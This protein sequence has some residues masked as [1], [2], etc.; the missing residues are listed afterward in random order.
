MNQSEQARPDLQA[1]IMGWLKTANHF[2]TGPSPGSGESSPENGP[3]G[4]AERFSKDSY[5]SLMKTFHAMSAAM[6]EPPALDALF[7]GTT[8]LPDIVSTFL[9]TGVKGYF[10]L[11]Q[12]IIDKIGR[13]GNHADAY[14]FDNIDQETLRAWSEIYHKEIRQYFNVPQ[15]G[16]NRFY[17][18]RINQAL[19]KFNIFNTSLA[20]FLQLLSL[21]FE[22]SFHVLQEKIEELTRSGSL[23]ED[24][25]AYYQMWVKILEGRFMTLFQSP[26]YN[27]S[28]G[29][30]MAALEDYLAARN[31]IIQDM[32][33]SLP[34][35]TRKEMDDLCK[36]MYLLKKKV[37]DLEK[38]KG[39]Q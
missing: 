31:R 9:L 35:P 30:T 8:I 12:Q 26:E 38:A 27:K 36:E 2:W 11:Q 21:P 1:M 14:S 16:L 28:L 23:P 17:Q 39:K 13:I 19:D 5:L 4:Q 10:T 6:S 3:A 15:L 29:E 20:E 32:L 33:Q 37:R 7:R 22:K 34:V 18:E 25:R 24:T